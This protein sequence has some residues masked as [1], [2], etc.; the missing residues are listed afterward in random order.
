MINF[1]VSFDNPM[2]ILLFFLGH[3]LG[4]YVFY[5]PLSIFVYL[6][7]RSINQKI[8]KYVLIGCGLFMIIFGIYLAI[9]IFIFNPNI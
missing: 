1:N 3:E 9:N 2:S 6:G 4:D 5:I 8:Y 7:G